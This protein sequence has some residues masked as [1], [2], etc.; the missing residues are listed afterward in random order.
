MARRNP[1][2]D[3]NRVPRAVRAA[4]ERLRQA[5][6][7]RTNLVGG[8]LI[9]LLQGREPKDWDI[10]VF[11]L[12]FDSL[13]AAAAAL[14]S[15]KSVGKKFGIVTVRLPS[16]LDLDLSVPRIENKVGIGHKG[17]DVA[18]RPNM[19]VKE[20]ARRRDFT[21][22]SMAMDLKTGTIYDP[23]GGLGDLEAGILRHTDAEKFVEDPLRA[24]RAAQLLARKAKYVHP[25]TVVLIRSIK[26]HHG[27]LDASRIL[28]EWRKLLLR[29][30]RPSMGLDLLAETEWLEH[31]PE[32]HALRGT[33]Q[34]PEWHPEGDVWEHTKLV[35]D[36]AAALR[37]KVPEHQR[38]GFMFGALLHDVGKPATTTPDLKSKG[39]DRAGV[40]PA[41]RFLERIQ[42]PKKTVV[43]LAT[44]LVKHHMEPAAYR[45]TS[46]AGRRAYVRLARKMTAMGGDL[47]VLARMSQA[48]SGGS[49]PWGERVVKD[50][51]PTWDHPTSRTLL[52][53]NEEIGE[54]RMEEPLVQGRDLIA[55]GH[56]PGPAFG[57]ILKEAL[58]LQDAGM[59]KK[60]IL[61]E[62]EQRHPLAKKN[63]GGFGSRPAREHAEACL[64]EKGF[65]DLQFIGKAIEPG[66]GPVWVY[67]ATMN[68]VR[69]TVRVARLRGGDKI[70]AAAKPYH[71]A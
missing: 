69:Y 64:Y 18:F 25:S 53:W 5:G 54:Q 2:V 8:A 1:R 46:E 63:A 23:Y 9:D 50:G 51:E 12:P 55:L 34:N 39:H 56:K 37:H 71:G 4:A 70:V 61:A 41:Q 48:D 58:E 60:R 19:T 27:E 16:G 40:E 31:Y 35:T 65:Y 33:P 7:T 22:N 42:A 44:A 32:L 36:T 45:K 6:S 29:A 11:G 20:A 57:L 13:E 59:P 47:T 62:I 30:E 10:E 26:Q 49:R 52:Q 67:R 38:E 3:L 17:F 43:P 24:L 21:I 28:E 15:A 68:E 14:G 66:S